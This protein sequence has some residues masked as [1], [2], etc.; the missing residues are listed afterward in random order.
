MAVYFISKDKRVRAI[1]ANFEIKRIK[2]NFLL[3]NSSLS[4][5]EKQKLLVDLSGQVKRAL[6]FSVKSRNR[7]VLT[8]R[9]GSVFRYFR[10][11]RIMLKEMASRGM[12]TGVRKSS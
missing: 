9:A 6:T 3:R 4:L 5:F 10:V 8:G 11:S 2:L 12:L 1:V 7:C